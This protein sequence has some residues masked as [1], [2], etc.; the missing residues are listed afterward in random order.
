MKKTAVGAIF[1][2]RSTR[3]GGG[4]WFAKIDTPPVIT[5]ELTISGNFDALMCTTSSRTDRAPVSRVR[6]ENK[7]SE[8]STPI[9]FLLGSALFLVAFGRAVWTELRGLRRRLA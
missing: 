4:S 8:S 2:T 6:P 1:G 5:A 7:S 9:F 3:L